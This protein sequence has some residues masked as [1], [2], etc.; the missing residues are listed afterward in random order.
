MRTGLYERGTA[1]GIDV[2]HL[3]PVHADFNLDLGRLGPAVLRAHLAGQLVPPDR[4]RFLP[5]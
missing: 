5:G 4:D 2:R 3:A 1:S